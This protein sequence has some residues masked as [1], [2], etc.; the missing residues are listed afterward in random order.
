MFQLTRYLKGF[1]RELIIGPTFKLTEAIF[2]LIVPLVVAKI[3]NVGI[4]SRNIG[5]VLGHGAIVVLLGLTGL[6]CALVCQYL[7]SRASQGFGTVV[8]NELFAHINSFSHAEIDRFGAPSLITRLTNDLTNV[9]NVAVM[10]LRILI[11]GVT[12]TVASVIL[13]LSLSPRL[14]LVVCVVLP[15]MAAALG[16]LMKICFPLFE[17][18]QKALDHLNETVQ[19]NLIAVRVVKSYVREDR[20]RE[21]FAE[22][23]DDLKNT[24]LRAFGRVVVN[25]PLM[26][27]IIYGTIIAVMWFGG[28][29]V[30]AG[31]LEAGKLITYFTYI[32]QIMMSLMMVSMIFMMLT[33]TAACAK[34][35]AE[36]LEAMRRDG[37]QFLDTE[38]R[39]RFLLEWLPEFEELFDLLTDFRFGGY[40]VLPDILLDIDQENTSQDR[41]RLTR[42]GD[43]P[44]FAAM[45][46]AYQKKTASQSYRDAVS[47]KCRELLDIIVKPVTA[48]RYVVALG[49]RGLLWE[50]LP[51]AVLPNVLEVPHAE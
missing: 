4:A 37:W 8:R 29:M 23:N 39:E 26:M 49:K 30:Y 34:R 25:M 51:D 31:S 24:S 32:T 28:Q 42:D 7:A 19:E 44:A 18:M 33:R 43:S 50:L 40:R 46:E 38:A 21:K 15:F 45:M 3:I 5:Y 16:L 2:E 11:R 10:C 13:T 1:K 12:M 35:V 17:K 48:V 47:A 41:K 22:R 6:G 27:L 14:A 9:Q 20:E 36:V